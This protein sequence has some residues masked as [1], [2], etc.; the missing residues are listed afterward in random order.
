M[1]PTLKAMKNT[2]GWGHRPLQPMAANL[3]CGGK[4]EVLEGTR[5]PKRLVVL[6]FESMERAKEWWNSQEYSIPK[7]IRHKTAL[8][9]MIVAEGL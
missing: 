1:S 7:Q 4:I 6:E 5:V 9:N 2:A 3:S 8:T